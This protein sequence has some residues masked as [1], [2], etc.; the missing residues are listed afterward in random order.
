MDEDQVARRARQWCEAERG[1]R[2]SLGHPA[3]G[4]GPRVCRLPLLE[5]HRAVW[6]LCK[7]LFTAH[8][9][10]ATAELQI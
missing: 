9:V 6:L 2:R 10:Q 3:V 4:G 8:F 7:N 5:A 1:G